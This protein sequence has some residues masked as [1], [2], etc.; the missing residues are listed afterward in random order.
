[1]HRKYESIEGWVYDNMVA[2]L[3]EAG[4]LVR[5]GEQ[6]ISTRFKVFHYDCCTVDLAYSATKV[7]DMKVHGNNGSTA[8]VYET[9]DWKIQTYNGAYCTPSG[10]MFFG[11]SAFD[12]VISD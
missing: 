8:D 9:L 5:E 11:K 7:L 12:G 4:N 2:D 1:M 6:G 10:L 3:H